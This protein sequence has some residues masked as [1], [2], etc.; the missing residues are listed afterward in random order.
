MATRRGARFAYN[1]DLARERVGMPL[2][3]LSLPV[4]VRPYAEG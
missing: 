2:L 4:K 3:S 1:G